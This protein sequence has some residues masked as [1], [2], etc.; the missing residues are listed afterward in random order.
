MKLNSVTW[1]SKLMAAVL[2]IILPFV[3][4]YVGVKYQEAVSSP[5]MDAV[6]DSGTKSNDDSTNW[7]NLVNTNEITLKIKY[8][9]GK[10]KY[11]GTVQVPSPCYEVKD[12][13]TILESFPEQVQIR[14]TTEI[15]NAET[16]FCTQVI[17]DKE[18]SGEATVSK[19]AIVSVY[20]DSKKVE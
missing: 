1:Y 2:F 9:G 4:F 10:L 13:T 3:G 5:D 18:F 11:A 15:P 17:T 16:R 6:V 20:L 8:E 19:D 7:D 12:E 14:V